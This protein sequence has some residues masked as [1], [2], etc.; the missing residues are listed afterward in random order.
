M[1]FEHKAASATLW[2][3]IDAFA[4]QGLQ[5]FVSLVLV[6]LL[7]P[8]DFGTVGL[9]AVFIGVAAVF[10]DS[11][12]SSALIQRKEISDDDLSSVFFFNIGIAVA[13]A[14][15]LC[16]AAPGIAAF[17]SIS[18]L[19]PLTWLLAANLVFG[20][21]GAIQRILLTRALDFR[22]QCLIT[23]AA[24]FGSGAVAI[25][26]AW[27]QYGVWSLGIQALLA[28]IIGTVL[29][30]VS[31]SWRPRW[32][33]SSASIR[34]L[35]RFGSFML[36]SGLLDTLFTRLN[37]LVIGRFYSASDL[38]Y[39]SRADST[40]GIPGSL[41]SAIIGRVAFSLFATA[42][43]DKVSLKAQLRKSIATAMMVNLPIMVGLVVTARPLVLVL[44]GE[45]WL[46]CVPYLQILSLGG[47]LW[48]LHV[49]NLNILTAQG[50]SSLFFRLEILKK[51]I[52]IL[53]LGAA[54]LIGILVIAWSS[55]V[56]GIISFVINAYYSGRLLD[57]GARSQILDL[58]PYAGS[59][60]VMAGCVWGVGVALPMPPLLQL[61][62][63]IVTGV[64]VYVGLCTVLRLPAFMD[65][66]RL[67]RAHVISRYPWLVST[68]I[69]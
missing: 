32:V 43:D 1:A 39:Y 29:L 35:F 13:A 33:F 6:R 61:A 62:V 21:F 22:K 58:L 15:L 57:Y 11:G 63:Q 4:R 18:L 14:A 7:T 46:P 40:Q 25:F 44:F 42:Q 47:I 51:L 24:Q 67:M 53:L 66:C 65:A 54:C 12:F 38:G 48:P 20:S 28:T 16:I 34:S 69:V 27:R 8:Q 9:L 52:G 60:L 26:L 17:F 64:V 3:G 19:Q 5:F 56:A 2:S 49:L 36:L 45:K 41:I 68:A 50:H 31:V 55:V 30:W 37:T 59:A 23:L 10:I